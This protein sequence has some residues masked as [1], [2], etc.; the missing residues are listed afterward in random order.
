MR[1]MSLQNRIILLTYQSVW[2]VIPIFLRRIPRNSCQ[3]TLPIA[4]RPSLLGLLENNANSSSINGPE[5]R[6]RCPK[7]NPSILLRQIKF[8]LL[9]V[10]VEP[11]LGFVVGV[12]DCITPL[13]TFPSDVANSCHVL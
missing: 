13:R 11:P 5:H 10:R 6:G 8:L 3:A 9:Q 2:S 7:S 4:Q 12:R 1:G